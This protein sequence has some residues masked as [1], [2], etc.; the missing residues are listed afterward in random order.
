MWNRIN[1]A[2]LN[3]KDFFSACPG[4]ASS[5]DF[6][7]SFQYF[8]PSNVQIVNFTTYYSTFYNLS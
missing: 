2:G 7:L 8:Y 3:N 4:L 1:Y 5:S 6:Y